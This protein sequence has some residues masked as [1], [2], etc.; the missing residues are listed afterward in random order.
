VPLNQ[1]IPWYEAYAAFTE[2]IYSP[3]NTVFFKLKEGMSELGMSFFTC[4]Q[5]RQVLLTYSVL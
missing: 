2:E 3:E 5:Y 1:V 4:Q